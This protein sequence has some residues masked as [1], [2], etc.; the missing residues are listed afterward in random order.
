MSKNN[1]MTTATISQTLAAYALDLNYDH[2]PEKIRE[3]AKYHI[4]DAVG[5]AHAATRNDFAHRTLCAVQG[6]S[7]AGEIGIIGMPTKLPV[8]DAALVNGA[9]VHGIDFDD[10]HT[11]GIIHTT[12]SAFPGAMCT[13]SHI[14]ASGRE[15]LTAY[16]TAVETG[17]RI[18]MV[19]NGGFHEK[20]FHP[21]G[22]VGVFGCAIASAK[23]M[24]ANADQITMAQGIALSMAAGSMEFLNVGAWT[25][26]MHPGWA[27][28]GGITAAA[29]ARQGFIGPDKAYEGRYGLFANYIDSRWTDVDHRLATAG[30]GT[31]WELEYVAV[32]PYPAC[33]Y[34]HASADATLKIM[35]D[36][37]LTADQVAHVRVLV[38]QDTISVVFEPIDQKRNPV[39]SYHAQFSIPYMIAVCLMRGRFGLAELEPEVVNDPDIRALAAKVDYEIDPDSPFPKSF[40]GEVIIETTDGRELRHRENINRGSNEC[41]L[42]NEEIE[43]KFFGNAEMAVSRSRAEQVRDLVLGLD[44]LA[45]ARELTDG[46]T[47]L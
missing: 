9:L 19:A 32:K 31:E 26:R 14:H 22:M 3:R 18:A 33:H 41:P 12:S 10:T 29:L 36:H 28:A 13:A 16:V 8:R 39:S 5:I 7:G 21:T 17:T 44:R 25:K 37:N 4:L 27:A 35:R 43:A 2:I 1:D 34:N 42:T 47:M 15:M 11:K 6:L 45:D 20:G 24:G 23:L 40:S 46:L 38:H 30:L